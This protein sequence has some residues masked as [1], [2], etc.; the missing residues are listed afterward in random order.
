MRINAADAKLSARIDA[1]GAQLD[2]RIDGLIPRI[3]SVGQEVAHIR[4]MINVKKRLAVLATRLQCI[5]A[6]KYT[7]D[8]ARE[9]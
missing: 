2:F 1:E 5:R 3:D 8:L 6:A 4:E 9:G 7:V